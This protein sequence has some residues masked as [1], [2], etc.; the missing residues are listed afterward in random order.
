MAEAA[1]AVVSTRESSSWF[2]LGLLLGGAAARIS[3]ST[4]PSPSLPAPPSA[5]LTT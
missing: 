4:A 3:V 1:R 5:L 2:R